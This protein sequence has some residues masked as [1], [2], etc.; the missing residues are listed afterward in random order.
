MPKFIRVENGE[1][2]VLTLGQL[3]AAFPNVSFPRSFPMSA[4]A[5]FNV[6]PLADNGPPQ[7]DPLTTRIAGS[8]IVEVEPGQYEVEYTTEPIP[9]AE[10]AAAAEAETDQLLEPA[11]MALALALLD[12]ILL[13]DQ[14]NRTSMPAP[15][16]AAA[17]QALRDRVLFYTRQKRGI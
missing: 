2:T 17:R 3:R 4:L 10:L 8:A 13:V 14:R 12:A 15:T 6:Y 5:Q 16:T 1:T 9:Q 11:T 7:F